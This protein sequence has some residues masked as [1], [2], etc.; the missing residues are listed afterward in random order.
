MILSISSLR[1]YQ[2][3][4]VTKSSECCAANSCLVLERVD[5]GSGGN[6][7][8][9]STIGGEQTRTRSGRYRQAEPCKLQSDGINNATF[10]A[11]IIGKSSRGQNRANPKGPVLQQQWRLSLVCPAQAGRHNLT[12]WSSKGKIG[13][14]HR[15]GP[16]GSPGSSVL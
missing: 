11:G 16:L 2:D 5:V 10:L 3:R 14:R 8:K 4:D 1:D 9:D 12:H 6:R 13:Q 15:K 7:A